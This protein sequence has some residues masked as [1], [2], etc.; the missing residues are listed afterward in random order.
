MF[1]ARSGTVPGPIHAVEPDYPRVTKLSEPSIDGGVANVITVTGTGFDASTRVTLIQ[2]TPALAIP[3][4]PT[5]LSSTQ[6]RVTIPILPAGWIGRV[7]LRA[8]GAASPVTEIGGPLIVY[9]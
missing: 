9:R 5:V 1:D 4:A 6:L 7:R 8:H 2:T 3:L